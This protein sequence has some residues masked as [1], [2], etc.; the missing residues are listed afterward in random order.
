M[1]L[2]PHNNTPEAWLVRY[3]YYNEQRKFITLEKSRAIEYAAQ[4]NGQILP[5]FSFLPV[6]SAPLFEITPMEHG[7]THN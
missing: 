5:L 6:E 2:I 7:Q 3:M 1:L 4:H